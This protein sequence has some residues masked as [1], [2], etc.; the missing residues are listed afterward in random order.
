MLWWPWFIV[1]SGRSEPRNQTIVCQ[2]MSCVSA[3][4]K[5][6][7]KWQW[8]WLLCGCLDT[9]STCVTPLGRELEARPFKQCPGWVGGFINPSVFLQCSKT[10]PDLLLTDA[11]DNQQ[12]D[13]DVREL[14]RDA[15]QPPE[16]WQRHVVC[17]WQKCECVCGWRTL[18]GKRG[19]LSFNLEPNDPLKTHSTGS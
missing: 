12:T 3:K 6:K 9:F 15:K 14:Q 1:V 18:K 2:Y 8:R 11:I 19:K 7:Q 5:I 10:A 4:S 17:L 13:G 16:M